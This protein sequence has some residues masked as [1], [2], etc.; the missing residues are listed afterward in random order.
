MA[1]TT[2]PNRRLLSA[3][4]GSDVYRYRHAG[5]AAGSLADPTGKQY[6]RLA[7][8]GWLHVRLLGFWQCARHR[9]AASS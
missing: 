8:S 3:D 9:P 7:G 1:N 5:R 2:F 6:P 4:V